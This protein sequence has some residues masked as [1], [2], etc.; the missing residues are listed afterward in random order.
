MAESHAWTSRVRG[1]LSGSDRAGPDAGRAAVLAAL[2][3]RVLAARRPLVVAG[4]GVVEAD[5]VP[6]LRALAAEARVGVYN[7]WRAKGVLPWDSDYHLGTIGL[8]ERD[9]E[10]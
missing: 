6:G 8:Q 3:D 9:V 10:L 1:W 2:A 5:A 7:T 4:S